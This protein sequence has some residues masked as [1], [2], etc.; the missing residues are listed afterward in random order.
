MI[1]FFLYRLKKGKAFHVDLFVIAILN[2]W[3]SL[4]GLTWMHGLFDYI[5]MIN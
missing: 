5:I 2:G 1:C 3:L 4:F